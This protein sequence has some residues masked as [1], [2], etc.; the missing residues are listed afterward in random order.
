MR[1]AQQ[2]VVHL[3][4][5]AYHH[6][7]PLV[8][9][10]VQQL[11]L[12]GD[13]DL[14]QR[15]IGIEGFEVGRAPYEANVVAA[16]LRITGDALS[17]L[18]PAV[19]ARRAGVI[20]AFQIVDV[21]LALGRP[22]EARHQVRRTPLQGRQPPRPGRAPHL[23]TQPGAAPEFM[24]QVQVQAA[25]LALLAGNAKGWPEVGHHPQRRRLLGLDETGQQQQDRH[26]AAF[27]PG[28]QGQQ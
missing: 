21:A 8:A 9:Q 24:Q 5:G 17:Q 6:L 4:V 16:Q 7:Q 25:Q 2:F 1:V 10:H 11:P 20:G 26:A 27:R 23:E 15:G 28:K 18:R 19:E 14:A 3:A 12:A 13:P 22:G